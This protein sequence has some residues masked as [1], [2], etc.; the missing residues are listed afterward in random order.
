MHRDFQNPLLYEEIHHG[1][2]GH[3]FIFWTTQEAVHSSSSIVMLVRKWVS[4]IIQSD[5]NFA[6]ITSFLET[7][8]SVPSSAMTLTKEDFCSLSVISLSMFSA[9][10]DWDSLALWTELYEAFFLSYRKVLTWCAAYKQN[11]WKY[12]HVKQYVTS[13]VQVAPPTPC[14]IYFHIA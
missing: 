10:T 14:D 4:G 2:Q 6:E 3:F 11:L 12:D 8:M 9:M 1:L 5:T 7:A 13:V